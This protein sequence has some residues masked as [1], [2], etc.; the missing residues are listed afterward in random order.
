MR[1]QSIRAAGGRMGRPAGW[2]ALAALPVLLLTT[3]AIPLAAAGPAAAAV[4]IQRVVSPQGVEI[5][6]VP[7][8]RVPV[9]AIQF[10]FR[11][12]VATDPEGKEGLAGML[13]R[14]LIEGAGEF[15][16]QGFQ[17]ALE[18]RA[19][20]LSFSA[21]WDHFGGAVQTLVEHLDEAVRMANLALTQPRFDD[22]GL[23]RVRNAMIA[24]IKRNQG[25]PAWLAQ[26]RFSELIFPRHPYG[27]RS[28]GT[29]ESLAG[30]TAEDLRG[31]MAA[32]FGRDRVL[33]TA[34]GA[35]T[36]D[37]LGAA[38]DRMFAGLPATATALAVPDTEPKNPGEIRVYRHPA[39]QTTLV[40]GQPAVP[41]GDPRWYSALILNYVLGGGG[42]SSR[43]MEEVR[44]RRGLTY[45]VYT[46][47][48][49][50]EH[51]DVLTASLST[52]N[53]RAGEAL[54]VLRTVWGAT[55]R[56]GITAAELADAK[57]YLTGAFPLQFSST[58]A[59]ATILLT[60][61]Q[62]DLGIDYVNQRDALINGVTLEEVNALAAALLQP[63]NLTVV[64]VGQPEGIT[65]TNEQERAGR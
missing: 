33:V 15:D 35:I 37:A 13:D 54:D 57:T 61:R 41:R 16:S 58:A 65:P 52:V 48:V 25:N 14:A 3:L 50:L 29:P 10:S 64:A 56:A 42:F 4:P 7:D 23:T 45:G 21:G 5:W 22:D 20:R 43:L 44:E 34:C 59:I 28:E 46:S 2:P 53:E 38:V 63:D 39:P 1:T 17:G 27:R 49:N 60:V 36:P 40:L 24:E 55:G 12:G 9:V 32:R 30:I 11:G 8:Q 19:I 18:E 26:Q 31:L 51:A 6:L 62:F 47:L